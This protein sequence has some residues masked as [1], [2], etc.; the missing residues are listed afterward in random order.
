M[1]SR[2]SGETTPLFPIFLKL[3][4]RRCLVVGAGKTAEEKISRF[5]PMRGDRHCGCP[6]GDSNHSRRGQPRTKLIWQQRRF[7]LA[8]WTASFWPSSP[9]L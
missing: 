5:A 4:K 2:L 1:P 6:D 9:L 3:A 7:E 8:T